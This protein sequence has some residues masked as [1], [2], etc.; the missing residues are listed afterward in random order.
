MSNN[1]FWHFA[2][3]DNSGIPQLGY[4]D[5]R[6]IAVGETLRVAGDIIHCEDSPDE[7]TAHGLHASPT[8]WD[9]LSYA[10]GDTL[11]LCRVTLGGTVIHRGRKSVANERTVIAMLSVEQTDKLLH[12]FARW[13]ALQVIHLWDA[14][15]V[16]RQ[17]LETGDESL[18]DAAR[19]AARAAAWDAAREAAWAAARAAARDAAWA[20]AWEAAWAAAREA[21]RAA[22]RA[23]AWAA[24]WDAARE[25]ATAAARAAARDAAIKKYAAELERRGSEAIGETQ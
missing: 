20:A 6:A 24:A 12:D 15:N 4:G 25:A 21:A 3:V 13:C 22:A 10:S 7:R 17:Y 9:A 16:V 11:V 8:V 5:G 19:E 18:R 1:L 14:P 2:T 23:A